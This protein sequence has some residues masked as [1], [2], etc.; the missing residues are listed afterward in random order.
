MG[1]AS[2]TTNPIQINRRELA[3]FPPF[4]DQ[5]RINQSSERAAYACIQHTHRKLKPAEA[6]TETTSSSCFRFN[7]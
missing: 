5:E 7:F 1:K 2:Y 3:R 4:Q 6:D